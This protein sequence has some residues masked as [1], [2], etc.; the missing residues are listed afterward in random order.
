MKISDWCRSGHVTSSIQHPGGPGLPDVH[1]PSASDPRYWSSSGGPVPTRTYSVMR[2]CTAMGTRFFFSFV[3]SPLALFKKTNPTASC[4]YANLW[5]V[6]FLLAITLF[7][8]TFTLPA[9]LLPSPI[10]YK[11]NVKLNGIEVAYSPP[12]SN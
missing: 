9:H 12:L 2:P 3:L 5:R 8:L 10:Y 4:Y 1:A 7:A 6:K 11:I